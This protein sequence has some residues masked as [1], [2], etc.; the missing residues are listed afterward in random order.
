MTTIAHADREHALLAPSAAHRWLVCTPSARLEDTLPDSTS[1]AAKE[2]T[3]AH[4][5]AE[6]KLRRAF[7]EPMSPQKFG[8]AMRKFRQHELYDPEM[9]ETT[10]DYLDHIQSIVHAFPLPP[11]IAV[12][13][14]VDISAYAP[15]SSGTSDCIIIGGKQLH[16]FDYKHG[17]GVPVSAEDNEQLKLYALGALNHYRLLYDIE[18]VHLTIVQPRAWNEP[19]TWSISAMELLAWGESIKPIAQQAF[20]GE[21][22]YVVGDHCT[23]C[24]A[25]E[26]CRA[27]V[28]QLLS[29]EDKA[30][31]KPPLISWDE[32][33]EVLQR[34]EGIVSWYNSLKALALSEILKGGEIPGWKAVEGRGSRQYADVDKAF[35][36]LIESGV[37]EAILYKREPLTPPQVEKVLK[38][39]DYKILLEEPGHV[40]RL[41]GKPTLAPIDDKRPAYSGQM[42]AEQAFGDG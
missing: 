7:I 11:H 5:I 18:T 9:E 13:R 17:K 21:G 22:D 20:D 28:T 2:G 16:I 41:P 39:K 3:L 10:D 32:V 25:K 14:R 12:E 34:S 15:E 26:T 19:S 37:D 40:V 23:F 29:V 38:G 4:E 8:A 24:R 1:D 33:G 42:T 31:A 6:L 35:A 27:R 30:P 36:H